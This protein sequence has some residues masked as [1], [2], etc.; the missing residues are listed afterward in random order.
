MG[1]MTHVP[2]PPDRASKPSSAH[3]AKS[4]LLALGGAA[5]CAVYLLNPTAGFLE[6][7]PDNVPIIGNLDEAAVTGLLIYCLSI[8]GVR[9]PGGKI[10]RDEDMK[11]V[12]PG[13]GR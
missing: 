7:I 1:G 9:L 8:L 13:S 10:P 2:E 6:F 4:K 5:L 3:G 11:D 12:G